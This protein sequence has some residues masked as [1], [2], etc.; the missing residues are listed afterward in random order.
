MFPSFTKA[1]NNCGTVEGIVVAAG[2]SV[3][4]PSGVGEGLTVATLLQPVI[5]SARIKAHLNNKNLP[6]MRYIP[7]VTYLIS[8]QAR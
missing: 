6:F 4:A 2:I 1:T 3:E 8:S 5:E 7:F